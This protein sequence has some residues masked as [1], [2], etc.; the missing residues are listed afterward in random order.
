MFEWLI[1]RVFSEKNVGYL[2]EKANPL[3]REAIKTEAKEAILNV[4]EDEEIAAG[5]TQ[6]GDALFARYSK[7]FWGSV[8][9]VQKGLNYA[10]AGAQDDLGIFD[11]DGG[12][13]IS[14]IIKGA[15]TGKFKGLLGGGGVSQNPIQR[16]NQGGGNP[17]MRK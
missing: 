13:S 2:M 10:V 3:M 9:G 11:E 12:I 16:A 8:G 1:K 15:L 5:L 6:Y 4:L 7:K 14:G 17:Y